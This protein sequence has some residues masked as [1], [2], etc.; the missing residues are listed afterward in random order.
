M[1]CLVSTIEVG[2]AEAVGV[3]MAK[4]TKSTIVAIGL[5]RN[6]TV[7]VHNILLL[8]IGD[9][10]GVAIDIRLVGGLVIVLPM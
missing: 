3:F 1:R 6:S 2:E 9:G 8:A 7:A 10:N 5:F 4:D